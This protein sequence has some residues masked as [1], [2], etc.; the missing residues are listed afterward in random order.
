MRPR[1]AA[2]GTFD[3]VH[4]GHRSVLEVLGQYAR[5]H[6]ME[7]VVITFSRHPLNVI[8]PAR[9]PLQL[10]P[11]NKKKRL[12]KEAGVSPIILDF[13]ED[14]RNTSARQWMQRLHDEYDVRA[15]VVG[16]DNTFGN[17]GVNLS[18]EEY[19]KLGEETGIRVLSAPEIKEVSSSAIR[20]AVL[21]GEMEK[22]REFL[23]RPYSITGRV[24]KG[25]G[26]G[27]NIGYPT[28]NV[29]PPSGIA[30]PKPGVYAGIV[31]I[32]GTG[33]KYPAMVNIG[34]RP[35]VMRGDYTVIEAHLFD[36]HG[37]LYD[38]EITIRFLKR[39]REEKKY[40]SIASLKKQLEND[41]E[42]AL[43]VFKTDG[44]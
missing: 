43:A 38:K 33:A 31:K 26:L 2:I 17:D 10:T 22:A 23:G 7:P 5:E 9:E 27:H 8:D 36:W 40:E 1:I 20:K 37:D 39:L 14:L 11:L 30:I 21:A 41:K 32:L 15:L 3:G 29:D 25:N 4:R 16:Y 28:A 34:K 19:R 18:L 42:E 35:T 44:L 12:L 13:D 24:E 6:D